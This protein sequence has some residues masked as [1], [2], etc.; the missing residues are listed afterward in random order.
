MKEVK[1]FRLVGGQELIATLVDENE[2]EYIIEKALM[3]IPSQ[4]DGGLSIGLQPIS[5]PAIGYFD[6]QTNNEPPNLEI[7]RGAVLFV[8]NPA[9]ALA[10]NYSQL[11]STIQVVKSLPG[12]L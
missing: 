9:H 2:L 10:E 12:K 11:T 4:Q 7:N 5:H 6:G 1:L 8:Y 3:V